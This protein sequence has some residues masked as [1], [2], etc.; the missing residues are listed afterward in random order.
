MLPPLRPLKKLSL[1]GAIANDDPDRFRVDG[2]CGE[3]KRFE[4]EGLSFLSG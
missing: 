3:S 2:P 4:E 1:L